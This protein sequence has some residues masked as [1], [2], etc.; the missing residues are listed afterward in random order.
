MYP[1]N[2]SYVGT[3]VQLGAQEYGCLLGTIC[4]QINSENG[5]FV[6]KMIGHGGKCQLLE[7]NSA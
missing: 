1:L 4:L 6:W 5:S 3:I 2:D 7:K